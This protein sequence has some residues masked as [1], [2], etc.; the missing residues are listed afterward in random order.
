MSLET[1]SV[2]PSQP[3]ND[4]MSALAPD[5]RQDL[6]H[7]PDQP[8]ASKRYSVPFSA[9]YGTDPNVKEVKVYISFVHGS[10]EY[11]YRRR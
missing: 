7:Y 10:V 5:F 8:S 2:E 9:G 3:L 6:T 4:Q 11:T 1:L